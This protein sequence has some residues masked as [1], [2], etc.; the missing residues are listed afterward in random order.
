M[1]LREILPGD[2]LREKGFDAFT[3]PG[4]RE[5]APHG[6]IL[7]SSWW[8]CVSRGF[9]GQSGRAAL[10]SFF[11]RSPIGI[12]HLLLP[13]QSYLCGMLCVELRAAKRLGES[14]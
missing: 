6:C 5:W 4:F 13:L 7:E 1:R 9:R 11:R 2:G 14:G 3:Q 8:A 12:S 10:G